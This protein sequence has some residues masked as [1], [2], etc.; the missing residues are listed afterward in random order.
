MWKIFNKVDI[1]KKFPII[2]INF[3]EINN[4]VKIN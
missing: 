2:N 3:S 4:I 1:E